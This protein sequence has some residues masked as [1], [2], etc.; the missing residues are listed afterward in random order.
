VGASKI[1]IIKATKKFRITQPR[2]AL[3]K[4]LIT[5]FWLPGK[6]QN[7]PLC[8]ACVHE[9]TNSKNSLDSFRGGSRI[10]RRGGSLGW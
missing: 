4:I 1:V 3:G 10:F 6:T 8:N 2:A 9:Q 7:A 5:F